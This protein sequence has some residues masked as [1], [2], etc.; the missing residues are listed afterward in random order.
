MVE[1]FDSDEHVVTAIEP[2]WAEQKYKPN[3]DSQPEPVSETVAQDIIDSMYQE[4]GYECS[5]GVEL[6]GWDDVEAHFVDI[7]D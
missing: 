3:D 2:V 5:C 4:S 7:S 6:D 1:T